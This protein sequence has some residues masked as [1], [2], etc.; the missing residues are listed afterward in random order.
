MLE[1]YEYN[2]E[3]S[4]MIAEEEFYNSI[5]GI[6]TEMMLQEYIPFDYVNEAFSDI[7]LAY[8]DKITKSIQNAWNKFKKRVD[9]KVDKKF[10]KKIRKSIISYKNP[11]WQ[12]NN[13]TLY[14]ITNFNNIKVLPLDYEG[15][16]VALNKKED[17]LAAFYRN[18]QLDET[19][20]VKRAVMNGFIKQVVPTYQVTKD[21]LVEIFNFCAKGYFDYIKSIEADIETINTGNKNILNLSNT[22]PQNESVNFKTVYESMIYEAPTN[23]MQ[24]KDDKKMSFTDSSGK[25]LKSNRNSAQNMFMKRIRLYMKVSTD[26]ITAKMSTLDKMYSSYI[27]ILTVAYQQSGTNVSLTGQE[28]GKQKAQVQVQ[29]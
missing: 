9:K 11:D 10:L 13:Y 6:L 8:V 14:D 25:Q 19:N 17:F 21:F 3:Y 22:L 29:I 23:P 24:K 27:K 28:Q 20:S 2:F 15:M 16:K 18:I 1:E 4:T 5:N 26:I 12:I 7:V